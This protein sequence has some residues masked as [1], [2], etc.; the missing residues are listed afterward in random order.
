MIVAV[1]GLVIA[2]ILLFYNNY[3]NKVAQEN[4]ENIV[5]ELETAINQDEI[6]QDNNNISS[7]NKNISDYN[8]NGQ[9]YIG[10]VYI[11][12]LDNLQVPINKNCTYPNLRISPC[13]YAG[14]ID[15]N[16]IVIAGHNYKST[17]GKL[18]NIIKGTILYFRSMDG[19]IYKYICKEV[20]ILNDNEVY[21]M[22][23]GDWDLTLFTCTYKNGKKMR[24][25]VRFEKER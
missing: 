10:I 5:E 20:E 14:N 1:I 2:T 6:S 9:T 15:D 16:N 23:T 12:D 17:F 4:A 7:E 22:Q 21:R 19:S 11:P 13:R 3:I 24:L 8:V 18:S 25:T